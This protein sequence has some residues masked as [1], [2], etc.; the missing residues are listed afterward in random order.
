MRIKYYD[1]IAPGGLHS[2]INVAL[3]KTFMLAR[4]DFS[5]V[6]FHAEKTHIDICKKKIKDP[7]IEFHV[8]KLL[9]KSLFGGFKTPIKDLL[10]CIYVTNAFLFSAK[11]DLII[12]G[13]A[14][15]F[16][17]YLVYFLNK[18]YKRTIYVCLHGELEV[19]V[20]ESKF[21]RNKRYHSLLKYAI[22]KNANIKYILLGES[23]FQHVQHVFK[24]PEKLIVIDHPYIYNQVNEINS[25]FEPLIIG[26]IGGGDYSKGSHLLF[27]LAENLKNEIKSG[28]LEIILVG[29]LSKQL[30]HLDN[31][32]VTYSNDILPES[33]FK[34]QIQNIHYSV[35]LRDNNSGKAIASGSFFDTVKYEKPF[36]SLNSEFVKYYTDKYDGCGKIFNSIDEIAQ[37]IRLI[38]SDKKK[39]REDYG[40]SILAI[41]HM[42][43]DLSIENISKQLKM[44]L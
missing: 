10:G 37:E 4:N 39:A 40:K 31:K 29:K 20:E 38:L 16:S 43:E 36:F 9:H 32:L 11:N 15:P 22:S 21:D 2:E 23:I 34:K 6:E 3:L 28:Q 18:F 17:Q 7:E 42:Q 5:R 14:F 27:R 1:L 13:L 26:Q 19:F 35:Q 30:M 33:I 8:L 25:N 24:S 12:F 44:Q 41:Q